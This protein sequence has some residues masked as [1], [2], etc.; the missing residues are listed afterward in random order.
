MEFE[1]GVLDGVV[2]DLQEY[3]DARG[4]IEIAGDIASELGLSRGVLSEQKR[5]TD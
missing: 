2:K 4:F 1:V 5:L 3:Q